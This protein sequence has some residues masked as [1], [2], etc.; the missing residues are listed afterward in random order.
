MSPK[1]QVNLGRRAT[2]GSSGATDHTRWTPSDSSA[3]ARRSNLTLVFGAD[4]TGAAQRILF[5]DDEPYVLE[6]LER[7]LFEADE[8]EWEFVF[9]SSPARAVELLCEQSFDVV[10]SDM[11]MPGIDGAQLLRLAK[12]H[13]PR[14]LRIVL[15]GESDRE[16]ALRSIEVTHQ[17]LSKPCQPGALME[18]IE[19]GRALDQLLRRPE[20]QTVTRSV[21]NLPPCPKIYNELMR[22][23]G[24][25]ETTLSDVSE[26]VESEP[27]LCARVLHVVNSAFFSLP[28]SV[29]CIRD[30]VNYL[31]TQ[32]LQRIVLCTEVF[33]PSKKKKLPLDV[34]GEQ[35]RAFI[36]GQAARGLGG[37][38]AFT[39]GI[40]HRVGR[41]VLAISQSESDNDPSDLDCPHAPVG[42]YLLGSWGLAHE[43]VE[44]VA[45]QLEPGLCPHPSPILSAL[46]AAVAVYDEVAQERR[47]VP[48]EPPCVLDPRVA[49]IFDPQQLA[50]TRAE[51]RN[52]LGGRS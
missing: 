9:E 25:D 48:T 19:R 8:D 23:M 41:L 28:R 10:V 21:T 46:H 6:G 1:Y 3:Q 31:G 13:Q 17:F 38:L 20:I 27:A 50:Q 18:L 34:E 4:K 52:A 24:H 49:E 32:T 15:S 5:V 33:R 12:A 45:Y 2:T 36:V 30:A 42:A 51:L 39:A 37:E 40:L 29:G 35:A 7:S 11:R 44:A 14:S 47:G 16:T 26:L 43:L 22:V